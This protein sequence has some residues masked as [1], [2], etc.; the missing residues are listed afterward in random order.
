M[1]IY[2][3]PAISDITGK[4]NHFD[5]DDE[6]G[7]Q[8]ETLYSRRHDGMFVS[9]LDQMQHEWIEENRDKDIP[10]SII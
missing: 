5:Y 9:R 8:E 7:W 10:D 1:H 6:Q 2:P 4:R 3:F